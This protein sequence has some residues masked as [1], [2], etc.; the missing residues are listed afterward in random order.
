MKVTLLLWPDT[1]E[2]WYGPLGIDRTRY[3][4]EYEGEW[5][6][7]VVR[8]LRAAGVDVELVFATLDA[9]AVAVH[10]PSGAVVHFVRAPIAYRAFRRAVWGHRWWETAAPAWRVAPVLSTLSRRLLHQVADADVCLLQD[11]ESVRFD[12]AAPVLRAL[13]RR[14]VAIDVGG[15]AR[16]LRHP[17]HRT[18]LRCADRLLAV[19]TAEAARVVHPDVHVWPV[20]VRSDV[21]VPGDRAVAR[22]ELGIDPDVPLV[23]SVGRL[24]PVKGLRDL[25]DACAGLDCELV[26]AGTGSEHDALI[27]RRQP[28][29]HLPGWVSPQ[30]AARWYAA[31]DVIALAS[32]HEGQPVAV[33]EAFACGRGVVATAV[34]GVPDVVLP[35]RTG[36]LV[37]PHD[38]AALQLAL[39][40]ALLDRATTDAYGAAG[41]ELVL[42]RHS[43]EAA[44]AAL[45]ELLTLAR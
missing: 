39:K 19:S 23:V 6:I 36:W 4:A 5:S 38:P 41:R 28:R 10:Q 16:P 32:Y 25:A 8:M 17:L 1:F 26:L 43:L 7:T 30:E 24:H 40:D 12:V 29:L 33:L 9:P 11:Y 20:P 22:A 21:F 31:A 15:S 13:G 45:V 3:L 2:D 18:A 35:G 14:V 34:G 27:N 44:G 42:A 37:E